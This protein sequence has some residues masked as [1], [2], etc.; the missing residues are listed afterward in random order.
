MKILYL[1]GLDGSLSEEKR[2]ALEMFGEVTAPQL[3]Y[4]KNNRIVEYLFESFQSVDVIIGSSMGGYA[5]YFL[6][7]LMN[8]PAL[9]FNPALPYKHTVQ[10]VPKVTTERTKF[11][12]IVIGKK[13]DTII[14]SD[15]LNFLMNTLNVNDNVKI[16]ILNELEHRIPVDIFYKEL[17]L[18]FTELNIK[19]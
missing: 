7:L 17:N 6:S 1:H 11:T 8:L 9:F 14:A 2:V 5:G 16:S 15:N 4:R 19:K 13:D 3:C 12:K 10:F 18:F